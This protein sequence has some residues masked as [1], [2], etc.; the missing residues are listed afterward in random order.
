[1]KKIGEIYK[2]YK[3]DSLLIMHQMRVASIAWKICNEMNIKVNKNNII[4]ACLFHD[5]G[6][7]IKYDFIHFSERYEKEGLEYWKNIQQEF[8]AK[9]GFNEHVATLII[10]KEIGLG[11]EV[12]ELIEVMDSKV[13][14]KIY[15]S[16]SFDLKICKYADLRAAPHAVVSLNE[17]LEEAKKRYEGHRNAFDAEQRKL[18]KENIEKIENQIFSKCKIKPEDINDETIKPYLEKLTD[19]IILE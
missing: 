16:D 8:I 1:M 5:M 18:F 11:L 10:N 19:F 9:Y 15:L 3:I 2:K 7:I 14:E 6:N 13:M 4:L 17:R 12:I